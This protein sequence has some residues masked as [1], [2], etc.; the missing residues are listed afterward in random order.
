MLMDLKNV[1]GIIR[2]S[3]VFFVCVCVCVCVSVRETETDR[4][5][6]RQTDSVDELVLL[7]IALRSH[8]LR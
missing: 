6:D 7:Y 3:D 2:K 1:Q 8:L 4:Q 5:T